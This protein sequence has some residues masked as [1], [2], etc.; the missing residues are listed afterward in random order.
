MAKSKT[1]THSTTSAA[2]AAA[3]A[4]SNVPTSITIV[5]ESTPLVP[6]HGQITTP[7]SSSTVTDAKVLSLSH[8]PATRKKE[9]AGLVLLTLS[10]LAFTLSSLFVKEA[11]FT[12][13]SLEIV[14]ARA[15][16]QCILALISCIVLRINPLGDKPGTRLW[17]LLRAVIGSLGLILFFYSLVHLSLTEATVLFFLGP[18][19]TVVLLSILFNDPFTVFDGFCSVLCVVGVVL[20]SQPHHLFGKQTISSSEQEHDRKRTIAIVCALLGALMSAAAYV[21]VRKVGKG[22]HFMVH[23]FYAG[24]VAAVISPLVLFLLFQ[25]TIPPIERYSTHEWTQL[26]LVGLLAF[27]GQCLL[28]QGVKLAPPGPGTLMR[29]N[30]VV[31]AFFIGAII[32]NEQFNMYSIIGAALVMGMTTALGVHRW[33]L[34]AAARRLQ[35]QRRHSTRE[36]THHPR[37]SQ[38]HD[39]KTLPH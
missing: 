13:S 14:F 20:L 12:I 35:H 2:T 19:F 28:H 6:K 18:A 15:I 31:F 36:R 11:G 10:S 5:N 8:E 33:Q 26:A 25:Q 39:R 22:I 4:S 37:S 9:I 29:M 1:T 3:T 24:V 27:L 23:V 17:L 38:H 21:V 32:F 7:S 16:V 34:D 30:D